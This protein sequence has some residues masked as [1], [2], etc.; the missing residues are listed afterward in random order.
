M[1]TDKFDTAVDIV[2]RLPED[3]PVKLTNDDRLQFY[4]LFKQANEGDVKT[5]RPGMFDFTG[6]AKW[7]AWKG[8]EGMPQEE[9]KEK[10]VAL[11]LEFLNKGAE[12][13]EIKKFIAE[14][15]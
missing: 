14:L 15:A 5:T 7:D 4:A 6:K 11:L 10:Y 2:K 1:S 8:V 13:E 3:G 9:A 12:D